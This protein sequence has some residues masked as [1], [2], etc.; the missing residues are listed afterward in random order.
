MRLGMTRR[1]KSDGALCFSFGKSTK[2]PMVVEYQYFLNEKTLNLLCLTCKPRIFQSERCERHG[3][4]QKLNRT[5]VF[6]S[7][8][9]TAQQ[10]L[11][12][13]LSN[14]GLEHSSTGLTL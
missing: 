9:S 12:E 8:W 5:Y 3:P 14:R 1:C 4:E 13:C 6:A 2:K 10:D 11:R 7:A